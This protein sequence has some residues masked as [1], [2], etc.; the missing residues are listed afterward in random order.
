M[1]KFSLFKVLS[2]FAIAA[3]GAVAVGVGLSAKSVGVANAADGDPADYYIVGKGSFSTQDWSTSGGVRMVAHGSDKGAIYHQLL[4]EGDVFKG[5]HATN[6][7]W[8]GYSDIS[9]G[10]D[11][12][13]EAVYGNVL[14]E[15]T[16]TGWDGASWTSSTQTG[17]P[18]YVEKGTTFPVYIKIS[19]SSWI[20]SNAKTGFRSYTDDTGVVY[21]GK[22]ISGSYGTSGYVVKVDVPVSALNYGFQIVRLNSTASEGAT[23]VNKNY[24]WNYSNT[25]ESNAEGTQGKFQSNTNI[26][27]KTTAYYDIYLGSDSKFYI[28]DAITNWANDYLHM[29][30]Y[31]KGGSEGSTKGSGLCTSYYS[32]AKEHLLAMGSG[33]VS[34]FSSNTGSKYTAA[35]ARYNE[36]ARINNDS[37]PFENNGS[38]SLVL[39]RPFDILG[40]SDMTIT[41]VV[42][43]LAS[44]SAVAGLFFIRKRK[45]I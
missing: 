45:H 29:Q 4:T 37:T 18:S 30:D 19:N 17:A 41:I 1:K 35:L 11:L 33:A 36:W 40:S 21:V 27:V 3:A 20:Q 43:S 7:W 26:Y 25:C 39:N 23:Y 14:Y 42:I 9:G 44:V 10:K 15:V 13:G 22:K 8:Y 31:D 28:G 34:Y 24:I 16:G 12:F 2:I 32:V 5:R 38:G 6:D